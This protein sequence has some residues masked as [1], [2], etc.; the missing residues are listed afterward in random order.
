MSGNTI[1]P[2]TFRA[3]QD[4]AGAEF[5]TELIDAFLQEAPRML[6]ELSAAQAAGSVDRFRRAAHSLKSNSLTFGATALGE[7]AR[8]LEL[9]AAAAVRDGAASR[10]AALAAEYARVAASLRELRD[11]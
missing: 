1:D 5:V 3:L 6:D 10:L 11:A 2:A 9:G 4:S 8:E 7:L